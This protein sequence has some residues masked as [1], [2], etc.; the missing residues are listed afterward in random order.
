MFPTVGRYMQG[1]AFISY[2][3][4]TTLQHKDSFENLGLCVQFIDSDAMHTNGLNNNIC[5]VVA[6]QDEIIS[7]GKSDSE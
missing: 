1:D 5:Q 6:G 7:I 2:D 4:S 3:S